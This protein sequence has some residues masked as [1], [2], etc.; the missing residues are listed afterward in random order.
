MLKA[1][2]AGLEKLKVYY[3]ETQ[4]VHGNLYTIGTILAPQHKLQF[5]LTPEWADNDFQWRHTY[6]DFLKEYL[7]PYTEQ[8]SNSQGPTNQSSSGYKVDEIER[9]FDCDSQQTT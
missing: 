6:L 3:N 7:Q 9:L 8:Q 5:F 1:L 2:D 4:E